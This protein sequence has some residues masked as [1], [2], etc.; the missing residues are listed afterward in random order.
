MHSLILAEINEE[1]VEPDQIIW[2]FTL[3]HCQS[4][5]FPQPLTLFSPSCIILWLTRCVCRKYRLLHVST[6]I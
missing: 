2:I 6:F 3:L 5:T 4:V 1:I